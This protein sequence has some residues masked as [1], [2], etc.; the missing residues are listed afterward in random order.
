M[1]KLKVNEYLS[2]QVKVTSSSYYKW[3]ALK[4]PDFAD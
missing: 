3:K 4:A 2:Q 1:R